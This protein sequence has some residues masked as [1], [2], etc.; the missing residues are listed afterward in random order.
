[1]LLMQFQ[2]KEDILMDI[3]DWDEYMKTHHIKIYTE[4]ELR[5]KKLIESV[6]KAA[7]FLRRHKI[8]ILK[9]MDRRAHASET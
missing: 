3:T 1:M 6:R 7:G 4:E 5:R 2:I 9:A 8:E